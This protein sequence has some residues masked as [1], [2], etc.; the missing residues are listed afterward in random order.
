MIR[1]EFPTQTSYF[2]TQLSWC[3]NIQMVNESLLTVSECP[4]LGLESLKVKDTQLRASSFKRRGLGPHR[5]R[6]NIQVTRQKYNLLY[7]TCRATISLCF[8][9]VS[10]SGIV[11]GDIYDGAWCAQ[12]RDKKQWLEVDARRLTRFTGVIL[13]GR[14][15]IWRSVLEVKVYR[16]SE[17]TGKCSF[18]EKFT[19]KVV[20]FWTRAPLQDVILY[21]LQNYM[22]LVHTQLGRGA[23]LQGPVQ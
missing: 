21:V 22:C 16:V 1:A 11:D 18:V 17:R 5:G 2:A 3:N 6:L 4:P 9:C 12:Y 15:S 10:Q 20:S 23:H 7:A 8:L 13:Q 19:F 14:N